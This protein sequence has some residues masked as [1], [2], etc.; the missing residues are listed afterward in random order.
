[1]RP[2][3]VKVEQERAREFAKL[4][5]KARGDA[6]RESEAL[7]AALKRG[8]PLREVH[9]AAHFAHMTTGTLFGEAAWLAEARKRLAAAR[10]GK[11][12]RRRGD[13][14]EVLGWRDP[15]VDYN[16]RRARE[17]PKA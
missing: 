11:R 3:R 5:G 8:A 17:A 2:E 13:M 9:R 7:V 1:M 15:I 16:A 4:Y 12:M 10:A 14:L 6:I